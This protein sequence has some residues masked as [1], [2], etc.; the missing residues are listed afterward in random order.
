MS[1]FKRQTYH[2][3]TSTEWGEA[4]RF[5]SNVFCCSSLLLPFNSGSNTNWTECFLR[6]Q[7]MKGKKILKCQ[8][9]I[10][11]E[12]ERWKNS[13]LKTTRNVLL[14]QLSLMRG[15]RFTLVFFLSTQP[16]KWKWLRV[17]QRESK[18]EKITAFQSEQTHFSVSFAN[19]DLFYY[20]IFS[21]MLPIAIYL[22]NCCAHWIYRVSCGSKPVLVDKIG[23]AGEPLSNCKYSVR[24]FFLTTFSISVA[25]HASY[26]LQ[27]HLNTFDC[28][29]FQF[30]F[31]VIHF[32]EC[33]YHSSF[34]LWKTE[35]S[36]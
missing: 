5:H 33:H 9:I 31:V 3:H 12:V 19:H 20:S 30:H 4:I 11:N 7:Q 1:T 2:I 26:S 22:T 25:Q 18:R 14:F 36:I 17:K 16:V 24:G 13:H 21:W 23:Y 28:H 34:V 35:A 29:R 8:F 27:C 6:I 10:S 32:I 15:N